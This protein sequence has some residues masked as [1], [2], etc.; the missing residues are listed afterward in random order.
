[1]KHPCCDNQPHEIG[2]NVSPR[3]FGFVV[4]RCVPAFQSLRF[5]KLVLRQIDG[6]HVGLFGS[7][8]IGTA[9]RIS[10]KIDGT[11]MGRRKRQL[12]PS[13]AA[14]N[15]SSRPGLADYALIQIIDAYRCDDHLSPIAFTQRKEAVV[16]DQ[17]TELSRQSPNLFSAE[18][19]AKTIGADLKTVTNWLEV[20]AMAEEELKALQRHA[21]AIVDP[22]IE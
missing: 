8:G 3:R 9:T 21:C 15:E 10:T 4:V 19:V 22:E 20:G 7:S 13:V 14:H 1:M 17:H 6:C 12:L 16:Q 5:W 2:T 11:P 18:E